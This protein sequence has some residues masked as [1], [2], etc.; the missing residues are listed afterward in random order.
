ML[1]QA[2]QQY[3]KGYDAANGSGVAM[4]PL[5]ENAVFCSG[6]DS[7]NDDYGG[8]DCADEPLA[9]I[10]TDLTGCISDNIPANQIGNL[11]ALVGTWNF[12]NESSVQIEPTVKGT[13]LYNSNGYSR[14]VVPSKTGFGDYSLESS[15][16]Y[17]G[18]KQHVL[19]LCYAG[20]CENATLTR[21]TSNHIDFTDN[22]NDTIHLTRIT[23]STP[24]PSLVLASEMRNHNNV[25]IIYQNGQ[26]A[27]DLKNY[28]G[29]QNLFQDALAIDPDNVKVLADLGQV[30]YNLQNY[31]GALRSEDRALSIDPTNVY[32]LQQK[33]FVLYH[34]GDYK[35]AL[36]TTDR[37]LELTG[38]SNDN[39]WTAKGVTL[40][41]LGE[42]KQ[43]IT[44]F[45]EAMKVN[46]NTNGQTYSYPDASVTL[47]NKASALLSLGQEEHDIR[48]INAA[49][50]TVT[51]SLYF[52]FDSTL[53]NAQGLRQSLL[54]LLAWT[55]NGQVP[56]TLTLAP[57]SNDTSTPFKAGFWQGY[58]G[59][60]IKKGHHT[61]DFIA[62][63]NNGTTSYWSNRGKVEA[64]NG[65]SPTSN[66]PDYLDGYKKQGK[67]A[68]HQYIL[69]LHTNDNYLNFYIG[70]QDSATAQE[71]DYNAGYS[72][73]HFECATGQHGQ[74]YCTGYYRGYQDE[75]QQLNDGNGG[76][77]H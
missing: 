67:T 70:Y 49:L 36:A 64:E 16:A 17:L 74:E 35:Q 19:T 31:T 29:A 38:P 57:F 60:P 2:H 7:N 72:Q 58:K 48:D 3:V 54:D 11:P 76:D 71:E 45:D 30:D 5:G 46:V 62:G 14:M 34:L 73:R 59:I 21:I 68:G 4:C 18:T 26:S 41:A 42:Y 6:W 22:N 10:T 8:Q 43:A 55:N 28:T 56:T 50:Q 52:D 27:I 1:L 24:E 66:N 23:T 15:W 25:T 53:K 13:M 61:P 44:A 37:A 69:P 65:M 77:G 39:A 20:G 40:M 75:G 32:A 9:N 51:K 63:Y 47:Y 33:A 12:T